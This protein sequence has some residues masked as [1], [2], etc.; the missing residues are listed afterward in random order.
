M[1]PVFAMEELGREEDFAPLMPWQRV[2]VAPSKAPEEVSTVQSTQRTAG[3]CPTKF[4]LRAL[5]VVS[6]CACGAHYLL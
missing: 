2:V 6:F 1:S 5:L 4:G 3:L